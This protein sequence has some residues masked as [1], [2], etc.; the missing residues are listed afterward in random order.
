MKQFS[1]NPIGRIRV[2]NE[3]MSLELDKQFIPALTALDGF[4]HLNVLW[5]FSDFDLKEARQTLQIPKPYK[6]SPEIMG[7]FSTRAPVRP[8]PIALST[9][10]ILHIDHEKGIISLDYIDA[11][12]NTP[13]LDIKPYTPSLDRVDTP[14]LPEWCRHWPQSVEQSGE[15][16]WEK[17]FNF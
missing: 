17:E 4:S 10:G 2:R 1:V 7:I 14:G 15:F 3:A 11:F 6:R 13:F 5:W 9:A 12:D 8:N 16:D